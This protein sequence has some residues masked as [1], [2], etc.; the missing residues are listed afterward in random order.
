MRNK[1]ISF[2]VCS[3]LLSLSMTASAAT[4]LGSWDLR[5]T[6]QKDSVYR[7]GN[8]LRVIGGGGT[9]DYNMG[10]NAWALYAARDTNGRA[11]L[12]VVLRSG[13]DVVVV[14]HA[15]RSVRK[16]TIGNIAWAILDIVNV[17]SAAG[18][19]IIVN[20]ANSVRIINDATNSYRDVAVNHNGSWALFAIA[21]LAGKGPE[22]VLN[23]GTGVKLIDPRTGAIRDFTF[24]GYSAIFSVAQLNGTVGLEVI[25]RT[26][27]EVYVITGGV[28]N[29]SLKKY[30]A[31]PAGTAWA[32]YG[33]TADTNGVAGD[34]IILVLPSVVKVIRHAA[35]TS[36]DY[37]I[38]S[39]NYSIDSVTNMDGAAGNEILVSDTGGQ[40]FVISDRAGTIKRQ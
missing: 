17:N 38:G 21:D 14:S 39:Y 15:L 1:L 9:V 32:I 34:E 18:E 22:L 4:F 26:S 27:G 28:T 6:G 2:L 23:M 16:Y 30:V 36:K 3:I 5:G 20:M 37:Q 40:T 29:G 31:A 7:E 33:R 8:F 13:L 35:G 12:E 19:E 25:G 24:P 11:G 10:N